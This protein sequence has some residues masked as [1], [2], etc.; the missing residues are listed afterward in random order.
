M[1]PTK[2]T[3]YAPAYGRKRRP[4]YAKRAKYTRNYRAALKKRNKRKL[5]TFQVAQLNPFSKKAYNVRVPDASTAPSSSFFTIDS[6]SITT[7]TTNASCNVVEPNCTAYQIYSDN[8]VG[9]STWT[10]A[11]T[12]GNKNSVSQLTAVKAQYACVRPVAHAVR[13]TC[14]L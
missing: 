2:K 3:Y 11:A 12:F 1:A 6:I 10:W 7:S 8:N 9:G 4:A 13:L 5:T 14:P